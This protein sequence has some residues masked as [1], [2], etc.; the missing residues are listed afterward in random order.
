MAGKYRITNDNK[1]ELVKLISEA[2]ALAYWEISNQLGVHENT[3]FRMMRCPNDEQTERI[4]S[5]IKEIRA[6]A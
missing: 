4:K 6:K 3:F 1:A 2:P 5:A